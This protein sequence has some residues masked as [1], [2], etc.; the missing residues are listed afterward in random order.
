MGIGKQRLWCQR[1]AP[2]TIR[3]MKRYF[4]TA[5]TIF[6]ISLMGCVPAAA[7][8]DPATG[9]DSPGRVLRGFEPPESRWGPGHRGV[10]LDLDIGDSVLAADDGT[11]AFAGSVAGTP[12]ISIEHADGVRTTYQPVHAWVKAGETVTAGQDIG[13]LAHSRDGYPGLHWGALIA[14]DTYID[15]LSLLNAPVIRLKPV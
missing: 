2:L 6:I 3:G 14:K 5:L 11:V 8:V 1:L 10:D 4:S 12:V 9:K 13:I 15:P 7:Y